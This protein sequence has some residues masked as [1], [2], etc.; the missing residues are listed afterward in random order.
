MP[1]LSKKIQDQYVAMKG[2]EYLLVNPIDLH[3][4][5]SE[6]SAIKVSKM[7]ESTLASNR[8][9]TLTRVTFGSTLTGN[10]RSNLDICSDPHFAILVARNE[11]TNQMHI[12]VW[13]SQICCLSHNE[14]I[15]FCQCNFWKKS[16]TL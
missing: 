10:L 5:Q 16:L 2:S 6:I 12:I 1:Q 14:S 15:H 4:T 13:S 11:K 9:S 8:Q 3:P 7:I